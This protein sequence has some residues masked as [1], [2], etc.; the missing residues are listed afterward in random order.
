VHVRRLQ[1]Q[2]TSFSPTLRAGGRALA[3]AVLGTLIMPGFAPG[4]Q[5][6]A[7]RLMRPSPTTAPAPEIPTPLTSIASARL[8]AIDET[9]PNDSLDLASPI[10]FGDTV[11]GTID[12]AGDLDY[13]AVDLT[14]GTVLDVHVVPTPGSSLSPYVTLVTADDVR[15]AT[16]SAHSGADTRIAYQI[17]T[18][19]RYFLGVTDH[20]GAGGSG[21]GYRLSTGVSPVD[22]IEPN[23]TVATANAVTLGDTVMALADSGDVDFFA[24]DVPADT[25]FGVQY[26]PVGSRVDLEVRILDTDGSTQL[27]IG[28]TGV[29][30]PW[31]VRY[32]ATTTARLYVATRPAYR[33]SGLYAI[34][35][36]AFPTGP[37]DPVTVIATGLT[38]PDVAVAGLRGDAYVGEYPEGGPPAYGSLDH[39]SAAGDITS[40]S[41]GGVVS[42]LA[43]DG[44]GNLLVAGTPD[45]GYPDVSRRAPDGTWSTFWGQAAGALAVA[46][47]GSIWVRGCGGGTCSKLLR[48]DPNGVWKDSSTVRVGVSD[49]A[50]SPDGVLHLVGGDAVYRMTPSGPS[51]VIQDPDAEFESLAFDRD[52]YLYVADGNQEAIR[53][54]SPSYDLVASPFATVNLGS[55][56]ELMF[57]RDASQAMTSRLVIVNGDWAPTPLGG[58]LLEVNPAAV[59][60]PGYPPQ[61]IFLHIAGTPARHAQVG[62]A[63]AD[64]LVVTDAPGTVRWTLTE[65]NL[66]IG[67]AL[68]TATGVI[69]GVPERKGTFSFSVRATSGDR[70]G[71]DTASIV[72]DE[73]TLNVTDVV[74]ALLGA[75]DLLTEDEQRFVDLQGN[76]N[77]Q[78]DVGDVRAYLVARGLAPALGVT[79]RRKEQ[80]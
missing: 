56:L 50:F 57:L 25:Y 12:P 59:R 52:G 36:R 8:T 17:P 80:R 61:P 35:I 45:H 19:A 10:V 11:N 70:F 44:F 39:V 40:V 1:T 38:N 18:T 48:F 28:N 54:Y 16:D 7:S 62:A 37:G 21:Y 49:M 64:T 20:D 51:V 73:P 14:A 78:M 6:R 63:Y 74:N 34:E 31:S 26:L 27:V 66:P 4:Q 32:Y 72:V 23:N 79:T 29:Y 68:D 42:G 53:L 65:G 76:H 33:T 30:N 69:S 9:E 46:P 67:L 2:S 77:G 55:P 13:F 75:P 47:D 71:P 3:L 58:T 60:A 24:V 5:P 22:E 41:Y 43:V 15:L